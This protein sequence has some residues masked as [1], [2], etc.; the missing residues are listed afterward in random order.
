[1][2]VFKN[3]F[4]TYLNIILLLVLIIILLNYLLNYTI[5]FV[6]NY[7]V[8]KHLIPIAN[9]LQQLPKLRRNQNVRR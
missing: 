5:F 2:I 6:D 3:I 9:Y 8:I 4:F 1:M 7:L